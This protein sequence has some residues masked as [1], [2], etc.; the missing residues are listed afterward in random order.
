MFSRVSSIPANGSV[1]ANRPLRIS[2]FQIETGP[3]HLKSFKT[4]MSLFVLKGAKVSLGGSSRSSFPP[5]FVAKALPFA[6]TLR[7]RSR[8]F[9]CV[10]E[11]ILWFVAHTKPRREKK[12]VEYCQRQAIAATL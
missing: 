1:L 6:L 8:I 9:S 11:N 7:R 3:L 4:G 10:S 2:Y 5:R 12:V